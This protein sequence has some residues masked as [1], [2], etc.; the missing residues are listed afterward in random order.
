M[1]SIGQNFLLGDEIKI[2]QRV[3]KV[4][5]SQDVRGFGL[6]LAPQ[7]GVVLG[8]DLAGLMIEIQVPDG[9]VQCFL[10]QHQALNGIAL[11][12]HGGFRH[13]TPTDKRLPDPD[14]QPNSHDDNDDDVSR[15]HNASPLL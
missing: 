2:S 14:D 1:L 4:Q 11:S 15:V 10:L 9:C 3:G 12:V 7:L 6:H 5:L 8:V 13:T